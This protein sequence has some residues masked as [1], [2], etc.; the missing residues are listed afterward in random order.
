MKI[1]GKTNCK[2]SAKYNYPFLYFLR[3][4]TDRDVILYK[5]RKDVM[6]I[7]RLYTTSKIKENSIISHLVSFV[8]H[9]L[10]SIKCYKRLFIAM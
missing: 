7:D 6:I 9:T 10:E 5:I 3:H 8:M 2:I 4:N 1:H